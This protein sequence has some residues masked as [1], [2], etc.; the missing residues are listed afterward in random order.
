[1]RF[2]PGDRVGV[3]VQHLQARYA[4]V[5]RAREFPPYMALQ[6]ETILIKDR[7]DDSLACQR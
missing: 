7:R 4:V 1:M 3:S 2:A 6:G 5:T